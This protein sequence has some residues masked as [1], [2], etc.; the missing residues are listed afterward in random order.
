M[1]RVM[2]VHS[3]CDD[4]AVVLARIQLGEDLL[5]MVVIATRNFHGMPLHLAA[6]NGE[7]TPAIAKN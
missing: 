7:S 3:L 5:R 2:T 1:S 4:R 6:N